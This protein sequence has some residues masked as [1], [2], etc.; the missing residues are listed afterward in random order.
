MLHSC[1]WSNLNNAD[2]SQDS[3]R[4]ISGAYELGRCATGIHLGLAGNK[5]NDLALV[6]LYYTKCLP[7][8]VSQ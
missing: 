4:T 2:H 7:A 6:S 5:L 8:L 1:S 3:I